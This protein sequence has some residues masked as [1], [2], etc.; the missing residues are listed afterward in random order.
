MKSLPGDRS[1]FVPTQITSPVQFK[2]DTIVLRILIYTFAFLAHCKQLI[3][4]LYSF[5]FQ[6]P[7]I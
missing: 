7:S 3:K 5:W 6:L 1:R 4:E 2:V